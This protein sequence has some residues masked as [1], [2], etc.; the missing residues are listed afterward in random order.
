L[1]EAND[2]KEFST[3]KSG[4]D[5]IIAKGSGKSTTIVL[6]VIQRLA[7]ATEESQGL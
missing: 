2:A 7:G 6:N 1:T 5:C 4:S 3:L